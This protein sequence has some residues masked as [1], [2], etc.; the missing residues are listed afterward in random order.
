M[1]GEAS[2]HC[3]VYP[4]GIDL[5]NA[6]RVTL[7]NSMV[8][9]EKVQGKIEVRALESMDAG[10]HGAVPYIAP[11]WLYRAATSEGPKVGGLKQFVMEKGKFGVYCAHNDLGYTRTFANITKAF[12]DSLET[13]SP[14]VR[15]LLRRNRRGEHVQPEDRRRVHD[16][17]ARRGGR[18]EGASD[19]RHAAGHGGTVKYSRRIPRRSPGCDRMTR[20]ST[21]R[22]RT[23]R[24][25]SCRAACR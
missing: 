24:T 7:S 22:I 25:A 11:T 8:E 20:S 1:G 23:S 9:L 10:A 15:A 17:R 16:A 14:V 19:D 18:H 21:L 4:E 3:E 13:D 2:V 5:A 12:A 6:L